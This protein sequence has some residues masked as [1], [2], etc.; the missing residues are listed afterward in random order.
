MDSKKRLPRAVRPDPRPATRDPRLASASAAALAAA[1]ALAR[2][3]SYGVGLQWDSVGY[4]CAARN[5]L[6]GAGF[7]G[8][9]GRP[10]TTFPPLYPLLLAA[11]SGLTGLDP[12]DVAGPLNAVLCALTV[13]VLGQYLRRRLQS[14]LL[15]AWAC[16]TAALSVPL[17]V[18]A[19]WAMSETLF[20]LLATL[21]LIRADAL[22]AAGK[23]RSLLAA[24]ALAGA[25][26]LT[27]YAGG[28]VP[29][30]V[31]LL[32]LLQRGVPAALKAKRLAVF[33]AIAGLP[34]ALWMLRSYLLVGAFAGNAKLIDYSLGEVLRAV[35][36]I[37]RRAV[38]T[39]GPAP[40][41]V[42][43]ALA[44]A[45]AAA[46]LP[47]AAAFVRREWAERARVDWL[48]LRVFAGFAAAYAVLLIA[49]IVRGGTLLGFV[50][51]YLTPLY[52]P[53]LTAAALVIDRFLARR[54]GRGLPAAAAAL[55]CLAAAGQI[56]VQA[57]LIGRANAEGLL[58]GYAAPHWSESETA[59]YLRANPLDGTV[60]SNIDI[61]AYLHNGGSAVCKI[62]PRQ[63]PAGRV[64]AGGE[65]AG[66]AQQKLEAWLERIPQ[67][68]WL[69]WFARHARNERIYD[70][71]RANMLRS[72]HLETAAATADGGVFRVRRGAGAAAP[73]VESGEWRVE[74]GAAL[75]AAGGFD[76]SIRGGELVY[77]KQPCTARDARGRLFL[78][79]WPADADDLPAYRRRQGFDDLSFAFPDYGALLDDGKCLAAVALP[80]Y[81][82]ARIE[83]G[84]EGAW[85]VVLPPAKPG[86]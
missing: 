40:A 57:R 70:F 48:P 63:R 52:I 50:P 25:A 32:L 34:M 35:G 16:F 54:R 45:L 55:L 10:A 20:I 4:I 65:A 15:T 36:G 83:T 21:A 64:P 82:A 66:G 59:R 39:V 72:P 46:L 49:A 18:T 43:A 60:Y 5:L 44:A 8:L 26:W 37:L 19:S 13:F 2:Q 68:A 14:R 12:L 28:A 62:V 31:A 56:L 80:G 84:K 75:R 53:L 41:A 33:A 9:S 85:R 11:V 79:V 86:G 29:A 38:E 27:R 30:A 74:S 3:A 58:L 24:A 47:S 7:I 1:L 61:L 22:L 76:V 69:V 73:P 6:D 71:G 81:A 77:R 23:T 17:A 78:R 51:R 67:G 42:G